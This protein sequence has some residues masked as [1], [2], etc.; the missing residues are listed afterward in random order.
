MCL[1]H[2]V[3]PIMLKPKIPKVAYRVLQG[4]A[5]LN[6][7]LPTLSALFLQPHGPPPSP[8]SSPG[9]L[10]PQSGPLGC[11]LLGT[12]FPFTLLTSIHHILKVI[13]SEEAS[14]MFQSKPVLFVIIIIV[15][16]TLH[17]TFTALITICNQKL[18]DVRAV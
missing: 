4:V 9:S 6:F 5:S 16:S 12:S 7:S 15:S 8:W 3:F 1:K 17:F 18:T 11:P 10:L 14:L 2:L 13:F